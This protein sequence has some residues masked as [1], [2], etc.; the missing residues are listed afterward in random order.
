ML[1][2]QPD[3]VLTTC[4]SPSADRTKVNMPWRSKSAQKHGPLQPSAQTLPAP[5]AVCPLAAVGHVQRVEHPKHLCALHAG[6]PPQLA[7]H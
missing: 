2:E 3:T 6:L 4:T 7:D 1:E 5:A